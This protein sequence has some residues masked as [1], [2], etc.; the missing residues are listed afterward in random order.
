MKKLLFV[1]LIT[2]IALTGFRKSDDSIVSFNCDN[3]KAIDLSIKNTSTTSWSVTA[4]TTKKGGGR[5]GDEIPY[6]GTGGKGETPKKDPGGNGGKGKLPKR[7]L[8]VVMVVLGKKVMLIKTLMVI[9]KPRLS[10]FA[11]KK[12]NNSNLYFNK[13][14]KNSSWG[15]LF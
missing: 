12:I 8:G 7:R 14:P 5:R 13:I 6:R 9:T 2:T 4:D 1:L 11:S 10:Y 3:S 15:F